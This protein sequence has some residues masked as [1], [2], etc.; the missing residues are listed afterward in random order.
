MIVLLIFLFFNKI[1]NMCVNVIVVEILCGCFF[2]NVLNF[3]SVGIL[4]FI[5][6]LVWWVGM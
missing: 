5:L 2:N 1:F 3:F 6:N 4:Y